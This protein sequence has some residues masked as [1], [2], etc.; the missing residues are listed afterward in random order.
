MS[1]HQH[2]DRQNHFATQILEALTGHSAML[3]K[4]RTGANM[5]RTHYDK[6]STKHR[7]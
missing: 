7:V 6:H 4:L 3:L 5:P 1:Q 2:H